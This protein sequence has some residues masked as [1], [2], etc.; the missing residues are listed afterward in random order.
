[1]MRRR[2]AALRRLALLIAALLCSAA[3]AWAEPLGRREVLENGMVLLTAERPAVPIVTVSLLIRAGAIY[4]PPQKPGVANL[5]AQML[6]Q[7]TATRTAP[8]ISEAIEFIG[9][10]LSADAGQ[11]L[12]SVSL[13]VLRKDLDT[14]LDLLADIL[15]NP[16]F[17]QADLDRKQ[18]EVIAGI[19]R[20]QEDPG[21]VSYQ[22]WQ[23]LVYGSHPFGRPVEGTEAA[24][25]AVTRDDLVRFHTDHVRPDQAILAVVGAVRPD[26]IRE[27]LAARLG[28][29]QPGGRSLPVPPAPAPL[30]ARTV[31]TIQR[32]VSQASVT[33]GHLGITRSNPD[34]YAV[35]VMNYLLGGG[36]TS[37]LVAAIRVEKGW[38]YDVGC[39]FSA[40][41]VAGDYHLRLQTRNETAREAIEAAL[42]QIRRIRDEP[43]SPQILADAR[44]YL[45]GSF[46]LRLDTSRKVAGM[47]AGIEYHG[48][49]LDYLERYPG[50][51]NAVTAADVQR[52][53]RTYLDPERYA[54]V[55]VADLRK[56][57]INP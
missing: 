45:T 57:K 5:V 27:K 34:Y 18:Q 35:Q 17:S 19:R 30:A 28:S 2:V 41:K 23:A 38:A 26:E 1:M 25:A 54:L 51:I 33:L 48:L 22:A 9:G 31:R 37:Y 49:G 29:W 44:A 16:A 6:T 20:E 4:D 50:L 7:G 42:A 10:S 36:F 24:V 55:A 32:E 40:G 12:L 14:G 15:R 8:E 53:A 56:A 13:S 52:V 39:A 21:T 3:A 47:L 11:E 43:V 46:P